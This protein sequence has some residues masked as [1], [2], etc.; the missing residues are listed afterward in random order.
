MP[1]QF[2]H[3]PFKLNPHHIQAVKMGAAAVDQWRAENPADRLDLSGADLSGMNFTGWNL[4]R[5]ILYNSDL[6]G[7]CLQDADLSE[8]WARRAKFVGAN[9]NKASLYRASLASADLRDADLSNTNMYRCILREATL[10]EGTSFDGAWTAKVI[11]PDTIS[12]VTG[13]SY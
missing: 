11:W 12:S 5:A 13:Y 10:N 6:S 8:C 4:S 7:A 3:G 9:L 1:H 2:A